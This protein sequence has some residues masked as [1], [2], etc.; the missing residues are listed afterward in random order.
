M[1][2]IFL[3][4]ETTGLDIALHRVL[5]I[6]FKIVDL[7][8]GAEAFTY[9]SIV[10]QP[11]EIWQKRDLSSIQINGFNWEKIQLGQEEQA[12]S[13]EII[14]IFSDIKVERGK[15]FYICQNPAFDRS[16][17]SQ[18][19]DVYTQEK[20]NWPYHWLDFASMH[21]ALRVKEWKLQSRPFPKEIH[22]SK[23][24]IAQENHLPIENT[25][26][27]ALNGVNHLILCYSTVVG[28]ANSFLH[29]Q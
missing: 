19:V 18:L 29:E 28:F 23:N 2:G 22:L 5:E 27:S 1:L 8:T 4:I 3:D 14:Q 7:Q 26:H 17:F 10:R 9:Q 20:N 24:V 12:V 25:P 16:F 11:Y 15:A 13:K 6:A 21:W